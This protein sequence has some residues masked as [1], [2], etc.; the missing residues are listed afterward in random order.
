MN[1]INTIYGFKKPVKS[2]NEKLKNYR[3]KKSGL[4]SN[5]N[6]NTEFGNLLNETYEKRRQAKSI[7]INYL[8]TMKSKKN[9]DEK[10][11][12][13]NNLGK[14]NTISRD[15]MKDFFQETNGNKFKKIK[16][17]KQIIANSV[18]NQDVYIISYI[19]KMLIKLVIRYKKMINSETNQEKKNRIKEEIL[20]LIAKYVQMREIINQIYEKYDVEN[21]SKNNDSN[22]ILYHF[23]QP[24]RKQE[25]LQNSSGQT[26]N[27]KNIIISTINYNAIKLII[28]TYFKDKK[29]EYIEH[30]NTIDMDKI[31]FTGNV[32]YFFVKFKNVPSQ[33]SSPSSSPPPNDELYE[34]IIDNEIKKRLR[35]YIIEKDK[36]IYK[37]LS[38]LFKKDNTYNCITIRK[39]RYYVYTYEKEKNSERR[40]LEDYERNS[41]DKFGSI[42]GI[43]YFKVRDLIK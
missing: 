42:I 36:F 4:A 5:L 37:P 2:L 1:T 11:Y 39:N 27:K 13:N 26:Y 35:N 25:L 24:L 30:M 8:N 9:L 33:S 17:K 40:L 34:Y 22:K 29:I 3:T 10:M 15:K 19:I 28:D 43:L 14:I 21:V 16:N 23:F 6:T 7:T 31:N 20:Y 38:I 41:L 32:Y 12:K 18:T